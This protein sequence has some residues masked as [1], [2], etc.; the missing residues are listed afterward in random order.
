MRRITS[1]MVFS[2]SV[3][4]ATACTSEKIVYRDA[5]LF[6]APPAAA[7]SFVGYSDTATTKTVCGSCHVEK[8]AQW[9]TTKHASAWKDL[10]AS[11]SQQSYCEPCHSV[12]QNGNATTVDGGYQTVKDA[13][14]HDV[15]CESCHGPGLTHVTS[16]NQTNYPLAS[17]L[18]DSGV[19]NGCGECHTGVHDPFLEEWKLSGHSKTNTLTATIATNAACQVC[20]VAQ[21]VLT[22]WGVTTNYVEKAGAQ[23]PTVCA[24]CHAPHGSAYDKQLRVSLS[25]ASVGDNLCMK[26]HQRRA[27]PDTTGNSGAHSPE[28]PTLLGVAGWFPPGMSASDSIYGT[29]ASTAKNPTLCA[30]CHVQR[31]TV[32]DKATGKFVFQSTGHRFLA[33][34]CVDAN[35]QPTASQTCA[36]TAQTF[37]SCVSG[38]CHGTEAAARSAFTTGAA[39]IAALQTEIIRVIALVKA[40]PKAS[41]C[42][43]T[44]GKYTTCRGANF[45][46]TLSQK[47]GS[48]VHNPF[49]IEQLLIASIAQVKKDY[50]VTVS[51]DIV[52]TPLLKKGNMTAGGGR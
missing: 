37:R 16:P 46:L 18:A 36:V 29:H 41:E 25:A 35:G 2:C 47:P 31:F 24:V 28:G 52:L 1:L 19:K 38:N 40:G 45:N 6:A 42:T 32:T 43:A 21:G 20:H 33:N 13:R 3:M 34:P 30:G 39:R 22:A 12:G 10:V 4:L 48:F 5:Q 51:A 17:I 44:T 23:L 50:G 14:Y 27:V 15:Q 11:G 26:C 8:Q 49:L 9:Q 7:A